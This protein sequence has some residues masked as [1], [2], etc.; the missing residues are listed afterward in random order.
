MSGLDYYGDRFKW[1][2]GVCKEISSDETKI[3]VRIFGIHRMDDVTDVS[4]GDLPEAVVLMPTT[5]GEGS[6][7]NLNMGIKEGDMVVG[8]FA[9]GDD[10]QQPIVIGVVPAGTNSSSTYNPDDPDA[11]T[12]GGGDGGDGGGGDDG[13]GSDLSGVDYGT[14]A[15][16]KVKITPTTD[17]VYN[18]VRAKFESWA[19]NNGDPHYQTV[20]LMGHISAESEWRL[21]AKNWV[22]ESSQGLIQWNGDRRV[23][24]L[25]GKSSATLSRQISYLFE[26][27]NSSSYKTARNK[28][29][30]ANT[31]DQAVAA[32]SIF[33]R[34]CGV[35]G[36]EL[37]LHICNNGDP[38]PKRNCYKKNGRCTRRFGAAK[39]FDDY[40]KNKYE[41]SP[42]AGPNR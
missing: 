28:I 25:Q 39:S 32:W 29:L 15:D 31:R 8:F 2:V 27:L 30:N 21:N 36:S 42:T 3:K 11:S 7:S 37:N 18:F 19:G 26:E 6:N 1:F 24:M 9:D 23:R 14:G 13:G 16:Q 12:G 22:G 4:D 20:A 40:Y 10:C 38:N 35:I 17:Y 33:I 5:A 34:H 41:G